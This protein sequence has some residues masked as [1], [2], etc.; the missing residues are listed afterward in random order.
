MSACSARQPEAHV[1]STALTCAIINQLATP[2]LGSIIGRRFLAG[3]GQLLLAAGG[4]VMIVGWMV[5]S[6]Y[7]RYR[8]A[9]G[10]TPVGGQYGWWGGWGLILFGTGWLW[11]LFT[12]VS[13]LR[14]AKKTPPPGYE[15]VPPRISPPP[16][17]N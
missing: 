5:R 12:S 2:G 14:Q 4:F 17:R 8:E 3:F 7:D 9:S 16:G 11:A 1:R 6:F 10:Q 15:Q 13:L